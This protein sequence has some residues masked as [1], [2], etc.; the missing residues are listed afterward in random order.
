MIGG[1]AA[2][3]AKLPTM[4]I[5]L[6]HAE[7]S[8]DSLARRLREAPLPIIARV[9]EGRVLLDLRTVFPAQDGYLAEKLNELHGGARS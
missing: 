1:G 2:P 8:A 7:L 4:L 6:T 5:A 9:E 3:G